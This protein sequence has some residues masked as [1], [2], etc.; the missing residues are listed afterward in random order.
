MSKA[1]APVPGA[2]VP[3]PVPGA[4]VV[5]EV[6]VAPSVPVGAPVAGAP[7]APPG[8]GIEPGAPLIDPN[9]LDGFYAFC[10]ICRLALMASGVM[11]LDIR[12][13][14]WSI[15]RICGLESTIY[16]NEGLLSIMLFSISGFDIMLCIICYT[17][18]FCIIC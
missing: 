16:L 15:S 3:V 14:F 7:E 6:P 1:P 8:A 5:P 4:L 13:G 10:I 11:R 12:S 17:M 18:G 9:I 2:P